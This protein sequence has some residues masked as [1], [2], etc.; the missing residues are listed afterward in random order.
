MGAAVS[1]GRSAPGR[2]CVCEQHAVD[3]EQLARLA[4]RLA[5]KDPDQPIKIRFGELTAFDD[6]AWRYPD[7]IARAEAAY[8][9]LEAGTLSE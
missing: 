8:R 3:I 7:F 9:A 4:A 1:R 5:G 6:V 2:P